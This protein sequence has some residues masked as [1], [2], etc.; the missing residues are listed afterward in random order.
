MSMIESS[1]K[2][3]SCIVCFQ[4][5]RTNSN[6]SKKKSNYVLVR[7]DFFPSSNQIIKKLSMHIKKL[8]SK[9]TLIP[10]FC[11]LVDSIEGISIHSRYFCVKWKV[12]KSKLSMKAKLFNHYKKR[13]EKNDWKASSRVDICK[14]MDNFLLI[15]K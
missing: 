10:L 13:K 7:P 8:E 1:S 14:S 9:S 2:E 6:I 4:M 12:V 5:N 15:K 3:F 11:K